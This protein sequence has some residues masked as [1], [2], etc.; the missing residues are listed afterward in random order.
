MGR[1]A[2]GRDLGGHGLELLRRAA[3]QRDDQALLREAPR[4]RGTEA[5]ARADARDPGDGGTTGGGGFGGEEDGEEAAFVDIGTA[6][7]SVDRHEGYTRAPGAGTMEK[8]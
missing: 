5:R 1:A 6:R 2:R 8:R 7:Q 4:E 3:G